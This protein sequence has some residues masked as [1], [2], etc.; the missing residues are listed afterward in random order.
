[1]YAHP[2]LDPFLAGHLGI[3]LNHPALDLESAAQRVDHAPELYEHAVPGSLHD[4]TPVLINLGID[5]GAPMG[6]ELS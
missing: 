3:S 6:L 2:K 1:M 5:Q 4:P